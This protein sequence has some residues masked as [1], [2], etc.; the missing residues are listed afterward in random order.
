[1][2]IFYR[3]VWDFDNLKHIK[4][5]KKTKILLL[6]YAT[7][8]FSFNAKIVNIVEPGPHKHLEKV[9]KVGVFIL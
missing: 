3:I 7:T 9:V 2:A 4:K 6:F 5:R 1:M 8:I